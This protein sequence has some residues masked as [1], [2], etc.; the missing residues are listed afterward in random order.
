MWYHICSSVNLVFENITF[1]AI[2]WRYSKD[3]NGTNSCFKGDVLTT[4]RL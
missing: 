2:R 1:T 3:K 4:S